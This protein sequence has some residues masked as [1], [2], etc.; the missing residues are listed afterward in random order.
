MSGCAEGPVP[1]TTGASTARSSATLIHHR[2]G[3]PIT[4]TGAAPGSVPGPAA[5]PPRRCAACV[6][7]SSQLSQS[8]VRAIAEGAGTSIRSARSRTSRYRSGASVSDSGTVGVSA[9]PARATTAAK[10]PPTSSTST[11]TAHTARVTAGQG[12]PASRP[13]IRA[14]T[15]TTARAA[16]SRPTASALLRTRSTARARERADGAPPSTNEPVPDTAEPHPLCP[17]AV[18]LIPPL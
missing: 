2:N 4:S 11:A 5:M 15:S 7:S 17:A 10:I 12:S 3:E 1:A 16:G 13:V 18:L 6:R 14:V 9:G 8:G